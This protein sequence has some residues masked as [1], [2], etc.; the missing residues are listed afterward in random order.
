VPRP[1]HVENGAER[2]DRNRFEWLGQGADADADAGLDDVDAAVAVAD[3]GE[4][5]V[6]VGRAVRVGLHAGH[7]AGRDCLDCLD[8]LAAAGPGRV[9]LP[10]VMV[11]RT[12]LVA[13][14][15]ADL[16]AA[17]MKEM[18]RPSRV[19]TGAT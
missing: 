18:P 7:R 11:Y 19:V 9:W 15:W 1:V 5:P 4:E 6:E 14:R 13:T 2:F 8:C 12:F 3:G 16:L 10:S 17:D